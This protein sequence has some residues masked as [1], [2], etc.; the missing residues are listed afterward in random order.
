MPLRFR[1]KGSHRVVIL[2]T[3]GISGNLRV[4]LQRTA[5]SIATDATT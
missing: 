5:T 1:H 3:S 4:D 2:R